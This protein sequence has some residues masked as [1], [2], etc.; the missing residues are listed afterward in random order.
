MSVQFGYNNLTDRDGIMES[1]SLLETSLT[2]AAVHDEDGRIWA[3]SCLNLQHLIEERL[4][5]LVPTGRVHYDNLILLLS[6]EADTLLGNFHRIL[7][8]FMTEEW[9]LNLGS[10]HLQLIKSTCP[11]RVSADEADFPAPLDV[12][13]CEL[14]ASRCLTRSL[15]AD[16]H[17]HVW[18]TLDKLVWFVLTSK[19]LNELVDNKLDNGASEIDVSLPLLLILQLLFD[20]LLY[21]GTK[22]YHVLHI[23]ITQQQRIRNLFQDLVDERLVNF[24]RSVQFFEGTLNLIAQLS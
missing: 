2:N 11:E 5:L 8:V 20:L 13:V 10:I 21:L 18:L 7:L 9:A 15:Q 16:E 4:L 22:L 3:N 19:H 12:L 1:L 17:D 23:D 14:G 6:E 24:L